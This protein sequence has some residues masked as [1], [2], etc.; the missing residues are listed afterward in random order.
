MQNSI[1]YTDKFL[2]ITIG[3]ILVLTIVYLLIQI[4]PFLDVILNF[5]TTILYPVIT[6]AVFYYVFRPLRDFLESKG[7][8]R[9]VSV[10]IIFAIIL[11]VIGLLITFIYPLIAPQIA[12]FTNT[13]KE[14]LQKIENKTIDILNIF[15]FTKVTHEQFKEVFS[16]Y[17]QKFIE[18]VSQNI[19]V[20][21]SSVAKLTSYFIITPFILY[22]LLKEDYKM[23]GDIISN[24]PKESRRDF[25]TIMS[26]IDDTL[27]AF[28]SSQV[29]ISIIVSFLIFIGYTLIGLHYAILL[30]LIA[31]LF[32]LIPF[33]GPFIS[34]I[35]ALLIGLTD[36]PFMALK[37]LLVVCVVHLIDLNF[38]SPRIVA[39]K[40]NIH[41]LTVIILLIASFSFF[42]VLGM[43]LVTPVYCAVKVIVDDLYGEVF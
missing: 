30:A 20:T 10:A 1:W 24:A 26:D 36:S 31:F 4:K 17:F 21:I 18:F 23:K 42:G 14:H 22:Y 12:E 37:V 16:D 35:P 38:L 40:L 13:P 32:N 43:L 28:I 9:F 41:P 3:A 7:V 39:H 25:R 29:L 19:I 27:S 11:C 15:N 33:M 34:T 2:R 6:A 5:V 8:P